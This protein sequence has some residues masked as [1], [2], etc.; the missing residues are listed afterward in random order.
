[1]V[2]RFIT[3]ISLELFL[4]DGTYFVAV[5]RHLNVYACLCCLLTESCSLPGRQGTRSGRNFHLVRT[6]EADLA[7]FGGEGIC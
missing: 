1:M 4:A 2:T 5:T 6:A 7:L 3:I